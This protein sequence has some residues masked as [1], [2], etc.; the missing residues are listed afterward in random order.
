MD[1]SCAAHSKQVPV[2]VGLARPKPSDERAAA[3]ARP[4]N[5]LFHR[6]RSPLEDPDFDWAR[7]DLEP[8]WLTT[9]SSDCAVALD[10]SVYYN[11][12]ASELERF[13]KGAA[14]RNETAL[15]VATIGDVGDR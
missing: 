10:P 2:H 15:V 4:S 12:G 13:L 3:D 8:R 1:A 7:H 5:P 11:R 9:E 14:A 6:R